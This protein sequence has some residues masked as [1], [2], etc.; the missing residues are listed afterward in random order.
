L[1]PPE[2]NLHLE[3]EVEVEVEVE[4]AYLFPLL[5]NVIFNLSTLNFT[6][7]KLPAAYAVN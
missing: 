1:S 4:I 6:S 7:K 3:V 2:S 5:L